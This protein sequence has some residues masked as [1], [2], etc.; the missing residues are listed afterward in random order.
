MA[1][2]S[3]VEQIYSARQTLLQHLATQG[4]AIPDN[5]QKSISDIHIHDA[6]TLH[7]R[8][9]KPLPANPAVMKTA[10]VHYSLER[11]KLDLRH[12]EPIYNLYFPDPEPD[13]EQSEENQLLPTDDLIILT[14]DEP[15]ATIEQYLRNKWHYHGH[16]MTVISMHR[17][18]FNILK[19]VLVPP[20]ERLSAEEATEVCQTY[21]ILN[22]SQLPEISRFS[23]VAQVI[24]LRPGELTRITRP[25]KTAI[26]SVFYR[27]CSN[28]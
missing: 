13:S 26:K 7:F 21:N 10:A 8:V 20:H 1:Q 9:Q 23:P 11:D 15:N 28:E 3:R 17:L 14:Y 18:Q 5:L 25:S 2:S 12:L 16:F 22:A 24:G 6:E 19:H 4:Y 27:M